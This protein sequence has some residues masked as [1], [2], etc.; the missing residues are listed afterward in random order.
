[1]YLETKLS[2][3]FRADYEDIVRRAREKVRDLKE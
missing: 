1:M 2:E 3:S